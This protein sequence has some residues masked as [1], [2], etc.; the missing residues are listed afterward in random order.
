MGILGMLLEVTKPSG[1]WETIIF[2]LESG[3]KNYGLTLI[4]LTLLIK[5]VITPLDFI[6]RL[7]AKKNSLISAKINQKDLELKK[8][9]EKN[10]KVYEMKKAEL[11]KKEQK[12]LL[13]S[14]FIMI[15]PMIIQIVI[16]FTMLSGL[17][18]IAAY[19]IQTQYETLKTTY[20]EIASEENL[21]GKTEEEQNEIKKQAQEA[22]INKYDEIKESFLWIKNIW[23]PD[24]NTSI[25]P[26]FS[27]YSS[28]AKITVQGETEEEKEQYLENLK[29][30]YETIMNPIAEANKGS[31]GYYILTILSL[32]I[33]FLSIQISSW[34]QRAKIKKSNLQ[35]PEVASNKIISIILPIIMAIFT[36][37][38]NTVFALYIVTNS[39]IS[40]ILNPFITIIV[41]KVEAKRRKKEEDKNKVSY[42]RY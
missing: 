17:N 30:E 29:A 28:I 18:S 3:I 6:N 38:Y 15:I 39:L 33:T 20:Y 9:Y 1:M 4:V 11:Y 21:N 41:D 24:T 5:V 42:S 12:N 16:F 13:G 10:P 35:T 34:I 14:C 27:E 22:V 8:K 31:N 26:N 32:I 40:A 2:G 19:K 36:L 25:I 37:F 7:T 23:R